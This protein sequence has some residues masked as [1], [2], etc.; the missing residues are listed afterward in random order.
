MIDIGQVYSTIAIHIAHFGNLDLVGNLPG[1]IREVTKVYHQFIT[2]HG[3]TIVASTNQ[4]LQ[5]ELIEAERKV[6]EEIAFVRIVA[7][8]KH[9]LVAKMWP[10][11]LYFA[12][13]VGELSVELI[14]SS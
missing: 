13:N 6:F 4:L 9:H 8:T 1:F 10:V 14:V 12:L 7:V 2:L 11:V 5:S 3:R